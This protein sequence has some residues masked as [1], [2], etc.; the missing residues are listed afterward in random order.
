[1]ETQK[2]QVEEQE[3]THGNDNFKSFKQKLTKEDQY[4]TERMEISLRYKVGFF[5]LFLFWL[6][7][8]FNYLLLNKAHQV[9]L[10]KVK[11]AVF[12]VAHISYNSLKPQ[13]I[14]DGTNGS[15]FTPSHSQGNFIHS[16]ICPT[17]SHFPIS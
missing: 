17:I 16:D 2:A 7:Y 11:R 12:Y 14:S 4:S 1:M 3:D 13:H 10:L 15:H 8:L 6:D 5:V 9:Y